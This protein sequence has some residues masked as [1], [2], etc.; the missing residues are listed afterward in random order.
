MAQ[1]PSLRERIENGR[2]AREQSRRREHA[3]PGRV[4]RDPVKLLAESSRGRMER[5]VPL[6][7]GRML[8][9]PFAFFRGSAI[10]QA[11]DLGGT[12]DSGFTVTACGDCHLANIGGFA[13]PERNLLIDIN[14][15]DEVHPAPWEWDLKRLAASFMIAARHLRHSTAVSEEASHRVARSYQHHM[16]RFAEMSTLEVWYEKITF[17][18]LLDNLKGDAAARR[19]RRGMERAGNRTHE[20]LLPKMAQHD[21]SGRW[22]IRDDPPSVF[23][24]R[25][26]NSLLTPGDDWLR[27]GNWEALVRKLFRDYLKTLV[28]DR[29]I[30]LQRYTPQDV[31]FKV[32]GVGSVGTRCLVLLLTDSH[33]TPL[34]LQLKEARPSVLASHTSARCD[35]EHQ[36]RRVVEGQRL[37]QSASDLFLGWTTGPNGSHFYVRQLRDMKIVPDLETFDDALLLQFADIAGW[38]LARAH[39]RGSGLAP[40]ISGYLGGSDSMATALVGYAKACADQN[41]KDYDRFTAACRS[42]RL[43]A[44]NDADY[45]L[46]FYV[47]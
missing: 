20:T 11:H 4:R 14:D 40:E 26:E 32:V 6:R 38:I 21:S 2:R 47:R 37:M 5:L 41:E 42:G 12:P 22:T 43:E 7:Y 15:F 30:L 19:I 24:L 17:D 25:G 13:T 35:W 33:E 29:R 18:R 45:E 39:A 23:H 8:A 46:D 9:S 36:G 34:F 3:H 28:A 1:P 10:L 31:A 16:H 44:R 27:F